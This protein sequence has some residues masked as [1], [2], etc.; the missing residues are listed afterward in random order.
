MAILNYWKQ[1][2]NNPMLQSSGRENDIPNKT[3]NSV[4]C[5]THG[6]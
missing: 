3:V 6:M 2:T 5:E 1:P 4:E